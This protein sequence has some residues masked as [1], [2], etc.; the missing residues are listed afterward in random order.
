M[1]FSGI[2]KITDWQESIEKQYGDGSKISKAIVCQEYMG[3]IVGNSQVQYQMY[4]AKNGDAN[5]VGLEV[6][7]TEIDGKQHQIVIQHNGTFK[8]NVATSQFVILN[9]DIAEELIG[10]KGAFEST[11]GGQSK[12]TIG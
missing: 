12:Y 6:I 3:D 10:V 2:F 5:F 8:N 9:S 4:Y 1:K 7:N 11:E